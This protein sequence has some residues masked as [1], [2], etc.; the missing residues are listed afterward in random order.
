MK[1]T[2]ISKITVLFFMQFFTERRMY[3][4][5]KSTEI[6]QALRAQFRNG[7][8]KL[9]KRVC[10]GYNQNEYEDLVINPTE[11]EIVCDLGKVS[12]KMQVFELGGEDIVL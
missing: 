12:W 1:S 6:K 4:N 7:T 8:S 5:N 2:A 11:A 9:A 10:F 3:M